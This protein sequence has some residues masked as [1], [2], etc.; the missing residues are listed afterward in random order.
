MQADRIRDELIQK[1]LEDPRLHPLL[2]LLSVGEPDTP[3]IS[4]IAYVSDPD[5]GRPSNGIKAKQY[6]T[7]YFSD[8]EVI[9]EETE[10]TT[11]T[12]RSSPL[13]CWEVEEILGAETFRNWTGTVEYAPGYTLLVRSLEGVRRV[14]RWAGENDLRLRVAGFRHTWR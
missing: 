2:A 8:L 10:T 9:G 1:S 4:S 3:P 13:S 5:A 11:T 6:T 14:V 12:T 7:R